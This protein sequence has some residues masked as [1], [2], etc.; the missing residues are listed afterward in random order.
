MMRSTTSYLTRPKSK[1]MMSQRSTKPH[2]PTLPLRPMKAPKTPKGFGGSNPSLANKGEEKTGIK[3]L[4]S[5]VEDPSPLLLLDAENLLY[6]KKKKKHLAFIDESCLLLFYLFSQC[7]A[8][9]WFKMCGL[10]LYETTAF[11]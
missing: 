1:D 5:F 11:L 9:E 6:K 7:V 4:S 3:S 10:S 2:T 8:Y